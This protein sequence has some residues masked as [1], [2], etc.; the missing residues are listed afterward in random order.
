L[1]GRKSKPVVWRWQA[2][3][4][5]EGVEGLTRDKTRKP[6]KH[7]LPTGTVQRVVDLA[8]GPPPGEAT[9]RWTFH[10]TATSASWLN[11]VGSRIAQAAIDRSAA[12]SA[13]RSWRFCERTTRLCADNFSTADSGMG[14]ASTATPGRISLLNQM[15]ISIAAVEDKAEALTV[16][17][18]SPA[19]K[20]L[21][22]S[23]SRA[24]EALI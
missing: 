18:S 7:P 12:R 13:R 22:I 11:A 1:F 19:V 20:S 21:R 15:L 23:R 2:R 4:V 3:F 8:L 5:A 24:A 10:F 9:H 16:V 14:A 6:G 17:A